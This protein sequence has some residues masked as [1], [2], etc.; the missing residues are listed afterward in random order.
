[1]RGI[2]DQ[3]HAPFDRMREFHLQIGELPFGH[4]RGIGGEHL[5]FGEKIDVEMLRLHLLPFE[6]GILHLVLAKTG[7]LAARGRSQ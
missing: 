4:L 7:K 5:F 2:D 3:R 6:L 1:M